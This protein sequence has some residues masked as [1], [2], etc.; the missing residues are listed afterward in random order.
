MFKPQEHS[1][2]CFLIL[3]K[4][5]QTRLASFIPKQNVSQ[6]IKE[7]EKTQIKLDNSIHKFSLQ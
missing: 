7:E 6:Q 2:L 5:K 1:S 3:D 4:E